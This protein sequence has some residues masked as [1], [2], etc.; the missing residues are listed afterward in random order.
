MNASSVIFDP[1]F[2]WPV[3]WAAA[4]VVLALTAL[5][6]WRG[7]K[8][9]ALRALAAGALLVALAGPS[10]QS[11]D[12][13]GLGDILLAVVDESASQG[14]SD[15]AAQTEAALAA[16]E[17]EAMARGLDLRVARLGNG[18]DNRGTLA[19][20]ALAAALAEVPRDRV[21]AMVL[22]SDGQVHDIE[23]APALPAPLH[24]LTTG[25]SDDWDRRLRIT[26]AP[27]FAILGEE[28]VIGL[29]IDDDGAGPGDE[30]ATLAISVDGGEP[31]LHEVP[32]GRDLQMPVTLSHGGQNVIQFT[33]EVAEGELTE[34]NNAAVVA[35]NGVRDRLRVLLVSGEPHPGTRTWRNLLK[36]DS[37]VDLVHFTILRPPE[38]QDGVPVTELSLIAFPTQELFLEKIDEF[39]LIIFDRYMLRGI[40]PAAYLASV[41]DYI[42]NGGAVLIS[43][44]PDFASARSLA[45]S[46]LG[47][48]L[49][50]RPSSRLIETPYL[51]EVTDLGAR[52]PVTRGLEGF[53]PDGGWGRWLRQ[54]ELD[55]PEGTGMT[56]MSGAEG[57]P[58]LVLDRVEDGR[59]ALIASDH[60]WLWARGYEGGG[61]QLEL[62]RRLAH[63][64]MKEPDLEEEA[65]TA[66]AKGSEVTITRR[67]LDTGAREVTVTGPDGEVTVLPLAER[68]PGVFSTTFDA[69]AMGLY[70]LADGAQ[71]AVIAVGPSA[72][73]EFEAT[74]ASAAPLAPVIAPTGGGAVALEDGTPTLRPVRPGRNAA[75]RGWIGYT[76]R[77]A[78]V[79]EALTVT[80]LAPPWL[81]LLIAAGLAL[82]AWLVEGR[83]RRP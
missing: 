19:M 17:R 74:L 49:P 63:W 69:P 51:P 35:I 43:A 6:L 55:V 33:T 48:V 27:A 47:E 65:L 75:G 7:L 71:E 5:A 60:A 70:R 11:E 52:H 72:P 38:K 1:A 26:S 24:L 13:A 79:V 21:A 15:R 82:A 58:L 2:A 14:L 18:A 8:G 9:W 4:A 64:M 28:Q 62:L 29:R 68:Q 78:Y 42:S 22:I 39:D 32:I 76:P 57:A 67:S 44:G 66:E 59:V 30:I 34:R 41:R 53:G 12:R 20:T 77:E 40:L 16:L 45:R 73:K 36:S 10:L 3:L 50:G 23:A 56:V 54:V 80:P 31:S 81:M 61:P 37:A 83:R 25:R 46:P